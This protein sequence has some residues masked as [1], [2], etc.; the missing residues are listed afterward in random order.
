[1][2]LCPNCTTELKKDNRQGEGVWECSECKNIWFI[3][4]I[5]GADYYLNKG[6][7]NKHL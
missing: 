7:K 4:N 5:P 2:L 6:K 1:M 3:L